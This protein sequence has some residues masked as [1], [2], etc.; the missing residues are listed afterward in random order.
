[1]G[2]GIT[3][4]QGGLWWGMCGCRGLRVWL[5][6][7]QTE[8]SWLLPGFWLLCVIQVHMEAWACYNR[9]LEEFVGE[10]WLL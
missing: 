5:R 6:G 9:L 7:G 8:G 4:I 10:V 1:M 2:G 3:G